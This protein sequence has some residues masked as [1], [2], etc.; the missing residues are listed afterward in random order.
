MLAHTAIAAQPTRVLP[1]PLASAMPMPRVAP[2]RT[3]TTTN[4]IDPLATI[5][6]LRVFDR[7]QAIFAEGEAADAVFRVVDGMI[8]LYK[9][10]PDGRRQIIG[11]LQAGDM[12]GLAFADRY[13]YSAEAITASTVQRIARSQLDALLDAQPALARRLLSVTTSELVAAQDQM[14]LL[15]RKSALEKLA[16]FLLALGRRA[17]AGRAIA[18]PMS[19][20]DIADHLGLTTETVSRGFTKLKT[21][22]LIRILDGGRVELLDA[23]AL[24]DLADCA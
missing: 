21:S 20:C 6:Q 8:R 11:F 7:E 10:L 17:G 22:R 5:A 18:L 9:L 2:S 12:V 13:L 23:E 24:A 15:G 3:P 1:G 16:S 4:D 14:L 19:R